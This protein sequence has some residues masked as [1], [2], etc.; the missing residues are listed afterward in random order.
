MA[1]MQAAL[2]DAFGTSPRFGEIEIPTPAEGEVLVRVEAAALT[3][4]VRGQVAGSH[5][6]AQPVFPAVPGNDG[7]GTLPDGTRVYFISPETGS[8]AQFSVVDRRRTIPIPASLDSVT[9]AALGNPGLATWGALLGRAGFQPGESVLINGGSGI[10]GRQAI[11]VARH[12]GA[13]RIVATARNAA[14]LDELEALGADETI[15]L[16]EDAK[17]LTDTFRATLQRGIDIVL[18]YLWGASALALL[19]AAAGH[20]SAR[21]EP[22]IRFIQIGAISGNEIALPANI[23]RSSGLEIMGSGLGSLSAPAIIQSL[24]TMY[25]AAATTRFAIA[26]NSVPLSEVQTAWTEDT[27]DD[28]LVF[29]I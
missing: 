16:T 9:A 13:K 12:L 27:G 23:L 19:K 6:S 26:T 15:L 4:L 10:A 25:E 24:T 17:T 1:S 5:Y 11:Q 18:D 7:V 22:R 8:M 20:G 28:R 14:A 3:N 29:T 21:G 2:V